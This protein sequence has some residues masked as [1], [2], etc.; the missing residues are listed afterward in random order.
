MVATSAFFR[1]WC[2]PFGRNSKPKRKGLTANRFP[3][4][5][6]V[7][8]SILFFAYNQA[9]YKHKVPFSWVVSLSP[10]LLYSAEYK[11]NYEHQTHQRRTRAAAITNGEQGATA[12]TKERQGQPHHQQQRRQRQPPPQKG[13]KS[14]H[15]QQQRGKTT[16]TTKEGKGNHHLHQIGHRQPRRTTSTKKNGSGSL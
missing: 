4:P 13:D 5:R 16:T 1:L 11:L 2:S 6:V 14:N 12:V 7:V 15:H 10:L 9:T 3:F 8:S